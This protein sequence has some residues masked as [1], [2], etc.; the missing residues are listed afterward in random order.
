M[1]I[2]ELFFSW[3]GE[4]GRLSYFLSNLALSVAIGFA[5]FLMIFVLYVTADDSSIVSL[6]HSL[7]VF[8]IMLIPL[9]I[10]SVYCQT[11]LIIKRLHDIGHSGKNVFWIYGL[12]F[13]S[14][15]FMGFD[16]GLMIVIGLLLTLFVIVAY[17]C[18]LFMP[19]QGG[20]N[21]VGVF[22]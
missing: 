6:G 16:S 11:V 2:K 8:G 21:Y 19:G 15:I 12:T 17:L 22:E 20:R 13:V 9:I 7:V 5:A 18:L 14:Q 10:L 3:K 1:D 4:I